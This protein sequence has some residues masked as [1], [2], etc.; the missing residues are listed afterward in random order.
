ML[1]EEQIT[2]AA[3]AYS[4][5]YLHLDKISFFRGATWAN[6]QNAQEIAELQDEARLLRKLISDLE[7]EK[8]ELKKELAHTIEEVDSYR[9]GRDRLEQE[10]AELVDALRKAMDEIKGW[11]YEAYEFSSNQEAIWRTYCA[12]RAEMRIISEIIAK[13]EK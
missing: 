13:Y 9:I 8:A 10:K 12:E 2:D 5:K 4:I 3:D 11:H 6:E 7:G 1:T